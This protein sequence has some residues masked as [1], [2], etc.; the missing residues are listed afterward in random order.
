V[1]EDVEVE[2]EAFWTDELEGRDLRLPKT[3]DVKRRYNLVV[4]EIIETDSEL[5][6]NG[7]DYEQPYKPGDPLPPMLK[8]EINRLVFSEYCVGGDTLAQAVH[9]REQAG[10]PQIDTIHMYAIDSG[11]DDL[12]EYSPNCNHLYRAGKFTDD[13]VLTINELLGSSAWGV[14]RG[15]KSLMVDVRVLPTEESEDASDTEHRA[16][17]YWPKPPSLTL[18]PLKSPLNLSELAIKLH[19]DLTTMPTDLPCYS[20]MAEA[21]LRIGGTACRYKLS[22][23]S[24]T[25]MDQLAQCRAEAVGATLQAGI[26]KEVGKILRRKRKA[27]WARLTKAV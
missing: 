2:W 15:L 17:T 23:V 9:A 21:L 3:W 20:D 5:E 11:L 10:F 12:F 6:A 27:G 18:T 1:T 24:T 26:D 8:L 16:V 19:G 25:P 13:N 22:C 4:L 14:L 7:D